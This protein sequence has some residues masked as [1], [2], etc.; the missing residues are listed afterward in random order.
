[1]MLAQAILAFLIAFVIAVLLIGPIGWRHP[2]SGAAGLSLL[3]LFLILFPALWAVAAWTAPWG[4]M[5]YGVAWAPVLFF[6]LLFLV[7]IAALAAPGAPP[8]RP[9]GATSATPAGE[10]TAETAASAMF[11]A[12]FWILLIIAVAMLLV[13]WLT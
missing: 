2:R 5:M 4:P 8:E 6:G 13:A 10:T 1:M 12:F 3:F 7:L 11:G 9:A